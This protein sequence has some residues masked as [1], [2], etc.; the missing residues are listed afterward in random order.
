MD[1]KND[2]R[3]RIIVIIGV[4]LIA[5]N[6]YSVIDRAVTNKKERATYEQMREVSKRQLKLIEKQEDANQQTRDVNQRIQDFYRRLQDRLDSP[7]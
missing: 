2:Y 5:F 1:K 3:A 6:I 4:L 7:E